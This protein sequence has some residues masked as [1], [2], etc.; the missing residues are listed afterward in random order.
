VVLDMNGANRISQAILDTT[1]LDIEFLYRN[2]APVVPNTN[3]T[4]RT[5]DEH[6]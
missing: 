3:P 4:E 2:G 5:D 6:P 1:T